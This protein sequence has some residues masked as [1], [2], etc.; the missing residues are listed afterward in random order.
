MK[1]ERLLRR[2]LANQLRTWRR[3]YFP[4]V[5]LHLSEEYI[6]SYV[7]CNLSKLAREI[8]DKFRDKMSWENHGQYWHLDHIQP[9]ASFPNKDIDEVYIIWNHLNLQPLKAFANQS[10]GAKVH[11]DSLILDKLASSGALSNTSVLSL[12]K[13]LTKQIRSKEENI[14]RLEEKISSLSSRSYRGLYTRYKVQRTINERL[15]TKIRKLSQE[16]KILSEKVSKLREQTD[17]INCVFDRKDPFSSMSIR[18][19]FERS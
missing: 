13:I 3:N 14:N 16:N 17:F 5:D 7:G 9:V 8:E 18:N 10:K 15:Q 6:R 2:T 19:P 4:D 1:N 12:V 11:A